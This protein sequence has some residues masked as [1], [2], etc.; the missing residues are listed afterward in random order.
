MA[1][2]TSTKS[3]VLPPP[4]E[5]SYPAPLEFFLTD[6][7]HPDNQALLDQEQQRWRLLGRWERF[8]LQRYVNSLARQLQRGQYNQLML[9]LQSLRLDVRRMKAVYRKAAS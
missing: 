1:A 8:K 5:V 6:R 9:G 7:I 3:K 4:D 2:A